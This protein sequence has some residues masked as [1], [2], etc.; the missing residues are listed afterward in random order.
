MFYFW[1]IFDN[2][3]C[4]DLWQCH[5]WRYQGVNRVL[6]NF[7][8]FKYHKKRRTADIVSNVC[9][10]NE[11]KHLKHVNYCKNSVPMVTTHTDP[12]PLDGCCYD[13]TRCK[14][15]NC[16]PTSAYFKHTIY[17]KLFQFIT[18]SDLYMNE[19]FLY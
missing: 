10:S 1:L 14:L 13:V 18:L 19:Y 17:T 16:F 6:W 7:I 4:G 8:S 11:D 12:S 5:V 15:L 9:I 2:W 3:P